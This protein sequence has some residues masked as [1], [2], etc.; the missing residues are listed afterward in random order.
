MGYLARGYDSFRNNEVNL[1]APMGA[2]FGECVKVDNNT[3]YIDTSDF[4]NYIKSYVDD[5][6]YH[7]FSVY[8]WRE[9]VPNIISFTNNRITFNEIL[10]EYQDVRIV[11]IDDVEMS[12]TSLEMSDDVIESADG[13][14]RSNK[15]MLSITGCQ[16]T[17]GT[18]SVYALRNDSSIYETLDVSDNEDDGLYLVIDDES[19]ASME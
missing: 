4:K 6:K 14:E 13:Q 18:S 15:T 1:T 17:D 11:A 12:G 8:A 7:Y 2:L 3:I 16:D 5:E 10:F 19:V 9:D